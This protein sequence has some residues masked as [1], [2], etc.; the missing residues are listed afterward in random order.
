MGFNKD[1]VGFTCGFGRI[2]KIWVV[3]VAVSF[4]RGGRGGR[5]G[6]GGCVWEEVEDGGSERD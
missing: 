5:G 6:G 4:G 1:G 3:R 2:V